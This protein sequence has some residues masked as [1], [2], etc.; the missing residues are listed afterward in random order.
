MSR[1]AELR[2]PQAYYSAEGPILCRAVNG[3]MC[4]FQWHCQMAGRWKLS[5]GATSCLV[6]HEEREKAES[7]KTDKG[8]GAA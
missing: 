1:S 5:V 2:C 8:G 4:G 6:R 7:G 3:S